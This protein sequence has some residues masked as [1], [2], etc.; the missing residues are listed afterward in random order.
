MGNVK[1]LEEL[2][3]QTNQFYENYVFST[4]LNG[5]YILDYIYESLNE[6]RS[7]HYRKEGINEAVGY[8]IINIVRYC[9]EQGL[10]MNTCQV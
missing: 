8:M 9:Y 6:L 4:L 5:E 1:T 7:A 2:L 10:D 3:H